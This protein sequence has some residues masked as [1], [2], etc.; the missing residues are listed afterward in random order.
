MRTEEAMNIYINC[1]TL[2]SDWGALEGGSLHL[3]IGSELGMT[4][5]RGIDISPD[6]QVCGNWFINYI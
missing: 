2:E 1:V 3:Q 4:G 6:S 5:E